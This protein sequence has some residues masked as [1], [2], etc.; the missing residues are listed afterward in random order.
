MSESEGR[1]SQM[2]QRGSTRNTYVSISRT[3]ECSMS[4]SIQLR[5]DGEASG[6]T[7]QYE[8]AEVGGSQAVC[9][10]YLANQ[11]AD[12]FDEHIEL[13]LSDEAQI[14]ARLDNITGSNDDGNY[15]VYSTEGGAITSLYVSHDTLAAIT[16]ED[17]APENA[18]E[19]VGVVLRPSDESSF[20]DSKGVDQD[21][22]EGLIAGSDNS[23][24]SE[25]EAQEVGVADEE[26]GLIEQ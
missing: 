16:G 22:V 10:F 20:E 14:N 11:V 1:N 9:A 6:K 19:S 23:D 25:E 7:T 4:E 17:A 18:P 2:V 15:G 13:E 3:I 21:E 8:S 26:V 24:D 5:Q 12:N